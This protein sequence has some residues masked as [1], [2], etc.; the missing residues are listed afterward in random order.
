MALPSLLILMLSWAQNNIHFYKHKWQINSPGGLFPSSFPTKTL[1]TPL[2][3]PTHVTCHAH[4]F[5]LDFI[6]W[7]IL[8][9]E[10]RSLSFSLC[11]FLHSPV[12]LPLLG[13]NILLSTLFSSTVSL[14]SSLIV[15]NQVSHSHETAGKITV[16]Y[17]LIFE[18]LDRKLEDKRF[19][20]KW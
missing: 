18:F 7:T 10:Y 13:P 14:H 11:S 4:P 2:L 20:T 15:S 12:T 6:T 17:I 3:S 8:G 16:L 1:Y 19:C 5:F 9:E